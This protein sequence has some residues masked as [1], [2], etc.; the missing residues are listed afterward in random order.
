ML[1]NFTKFCE[2][3][4]KKYVII[5]ERYKMDKLSNLIKEARPLYKQRKRRKAISR[6]I[7]GITTPAIL[8]TSIAQVYIQGSD[9]YISL[10]NDKLQNE[11]LED[12]FGF[13]R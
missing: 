9:I 13:L 12:D 5:I 11:L 6:M 2:H 4:S 7:L 3:I 8:F 1:R 10:D